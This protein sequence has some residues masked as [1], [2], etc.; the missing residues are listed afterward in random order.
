[1]LLLDGWFR[2]IQMESLGSL[3]LLLF[4]SSFPQQQQL[5]ELSLLMWAWERCS[6]SSESIRSQD[7]GIITA[8]SV[9]W[10][11]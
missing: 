3:C 11:R 5:A 1:M 7:S 2:S 8:Q 6:Q 10:W 9:F 4:N